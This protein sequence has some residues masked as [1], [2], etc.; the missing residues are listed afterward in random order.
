MKNNALTLV[1]ILVVIIIIALLATFIVFNATDSL[2]ETER[3]EI[4]GDSN[5]LKNKNL[6]YLVSEW[7]FDGPTVAGSTATNED[8]KDSWGYNNGIIVAGH[9]PIVRDGDDCVCGKC[10]EFNGSEQYI[11][12]ETQKIISGQDDFTITFWLNTHDIT[13]T[14]FRALMGNI[15]GSQYEAGWNIV[16]N[17]IHSGDILFVADDNGASPWGIVYDADMKLG[18]D[19][20]NFVTLIRSSNTFQWYKNTLAIGNPV[21]NSVNIGNGTCDFEIGASSN[22]RYLDGLLDEVQIYDQALTFSEINNQYLAG[23]DSLLQNNAISLEEYNQRIY[24]I[25]IK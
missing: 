6:D 2:S 24:K 8:V 18:Q 21:I 23:L 13:Q 7:K 5:N 19:Q 15:K 9:A 4:L 12:T 22:E 20:W 11:D 16:L 17:V 3:L 1:E 25:A 14:S 10:M